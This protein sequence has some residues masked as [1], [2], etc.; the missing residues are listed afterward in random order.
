MSIKLMMEIE[1]AHAR[2]DE[3]HAR[4]EKLELSAIVDPQGHELAPR[5]EKLENELKAMK[6]RMGKTRE[7]AEI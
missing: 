6:A 4:V 2:L 1:R 5:I 3:L 7:V